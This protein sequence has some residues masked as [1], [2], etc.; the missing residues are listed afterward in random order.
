MRQTCQNHCLPLIT[1]LSIFHLIF[2]ACLSELD[3]LCLTAL[4][5]L[6]ALVLVFL[7]IEFACPGFQADYLAGKLPSCIFFDRHMDSAVGTEAQNSGSH[8]ILVSEFLEPL[9]EVIR[10]STR[11]RDLLE[12]RSFEDH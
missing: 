11:Y 9:S 3:R 5:E 1:F 10:L 6:G 12:S 2:Q 7:V 8:E 4:K